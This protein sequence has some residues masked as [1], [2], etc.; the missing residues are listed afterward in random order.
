MNV[1]RC[2]LKN[3]SGGTYTYLQLVHNYRDK[4]TGKTKTNVL[5]KLGR[6]DQIEPDY[7]KGIIKALSRVVGELPSESASGFDF[8]ASRELGG[9]WLL[10]ALWR[11]LGMAKAVKGL[12][13]D[14][15]FEMPVERLLFAM[16]AGRILAPGSKLSL[17]HWVSKKAYIEGLAEV[18]VHNFYRAM[19]LLVESNE[20]LQQQVFT[21]VAKHASLDLD[22]IF[23]DTTNTYFETEEDTSDSGLLKRGHSK[24]GHPELPLVS[25]AF[26]VTRTGI[27]VR[28][29]V[30]PGTMSDQNI[31][32]QV[33][34]DLGQWNLGHVVMV[35]D[36]GFNSADNRRILLR[37]CGDYIIGEKLRVGSD[38]AAVEA[39]HR[40]GRYRLLENG[41][42]I[43]DVV[44]DEG[45]ATERRFIIVKNPE[46]EARD[47][48]IREQIVEAAKR[49]L[50]ELSQYRGKAHTKAACALRSHPAYGR[51]IKQDERGVL[52]I[53]TAKIVAESLLDGK[54]LV[55]TSSMKMDAA[56]VVAGYQ[57][58]WAIERV[59]KDLKNTLDIRPVYHRL[60]DRIRSHILICWLAMVL[61]R[62]AENATDRSWHQIGKALADVTAGLIESDKVTLWYCSDISDEA[63]D[64]F[65]RLEIVLPKKV[66]STEPRVRPAV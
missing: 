30:F 42:S 24:D 35:Q 36:A 13:K 58:L 20:A 1:R 29:W 61:V 18:D 22:L 52:R 41:L 14:R 63:K 9:V 47:R 32:E 38:G 11:R 60:D 55:S 23:L 50:E 48:I 40:K 17:E 31:V 8:H 56:D 62:Y 45:K 33:K 51:Y 21:E 2:T 25:I 5:M 16:V 28:C 6:E 66:L 3:A 12:L 53:D 39:L 64:V 7:I 49:K 26:A 27:P 57:Q 19:D 34:Q 15:Q 46:A 44:L 4:A 54:F 59:F 37:E 65:T 10:D 43:K